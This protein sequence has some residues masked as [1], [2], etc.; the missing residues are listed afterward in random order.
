MTRQKRVS[1][2]YEKVLDSV[3][4]GSYVLAMLPNWVSKSTQGRRTAG[5]IARPKRF[6]TAADEH[7]TE[8]YFMLGVTEGQFREVS[9]MP[10]SRYFWALALAGAFSLSP[11][12]LA[13]DL[14]WGIYRDSEHGCRLEYPRALFSLDPQEP[15]EPRRFSGEDNS[16]Y[17][18]IMGAENTSKWTPAD[19]KM[20]Y[21]RS[22]M[23]GDITYERTK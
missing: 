22:D 10:A 8:R 13:Q 14:D 4:L 19:I 7:R 5:S 2:F 3:T 23:P 12:A 16:T 21:L 11:M 17:F 6:R 20:K 18:R 15:G 9:M 1:F